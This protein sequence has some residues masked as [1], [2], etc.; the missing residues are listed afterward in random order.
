MRNTYFSFKQF[1]VHQDE[2]AMKVTTD[3]CIFGASIILPIHAK[4]LDVGTGTALL[5]LML[6]QRYNDAKFEA[7]EIDE[8]AC[9]QASSNVAQSKFKSQI[10]VAHVN[11]F[12]FTSSKK[13]DVIICNPPFF[14]RHLKSLNDTKNIAWHS[15]QFSLISFFER[16]TK[17]LSAS[18]VIWLL[19][20]TSRIEELQNLIQPY[21]VFVTKII[22][23][24]DTAEQRSHV[25]IVHIKQE[26]KQCI[27][28]YLTVK[29]NR[30]GPYTAD[31]ED[32]MRPYYLAID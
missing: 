26:Q 20:P 19:M 14:E 18:G 9:G 3:A 25:S 22:F 1:T 2:C 17:M 28:D 4:V 11:F 5:S 30:N 24:Q 6:A 16:A 32:L 27:E 23:V 21:K 29:Q 13:Y 31:F 15:N 7:I 8:K 12:S 10:S